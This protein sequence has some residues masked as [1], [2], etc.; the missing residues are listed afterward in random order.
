MGD[1]SEGSTFSIL[2]TT[3]GTISGT[4][5]EIISGDVFSVEY[6]SDKVEVTLEEAILVF[7]DGFE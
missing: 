6:F 1:V 4:F 5:D 7:V 2:T 3:N